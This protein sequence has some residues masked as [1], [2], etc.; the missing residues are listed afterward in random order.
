MCQLKKMKQLN[1]MTHPYNPS[2]WEAEAGG[3]RDEGSLGHIVG[4]RSAWNVPK[5]C[6]KTNKTLK[7]IFNYSQNVY[8][9]L[10]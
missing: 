3:L 7:Q 8:P 5:P 6:L 9:V 2:T 10:T 1:M 4:S